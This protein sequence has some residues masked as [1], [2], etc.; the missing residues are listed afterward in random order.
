MQREESSSESAVILVRGA[1]VEDLE[2]CEVCSRKMLIREIVTP[3]AW[4]RAKTF[5]ICDRCYVEWAK[6]DA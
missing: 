1:A 6:R 2:E 4:P 3:K 5:L